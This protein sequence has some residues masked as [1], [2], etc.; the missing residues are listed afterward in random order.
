MISP[1][2]DWMFSRVPVASSRTDAP[3]STAGTVETE[4]SASRTD[5]K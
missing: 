1:T 5:W 3:A 2:N 4:A